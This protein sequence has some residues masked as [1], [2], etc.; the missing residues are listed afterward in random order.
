[1][2]HE[3]KITWRHD[4]PAVARGERRQRRND[5]ADSAQISTVRRSSW[6]ELLDDP[7]RTVLGDHV[8]RFGLAATN[9]ERRAGRERVGTRTKIQ[10][11]D[12]RGMAGLLPALHF[13]GSHRGDSSV[14]STRDGVGK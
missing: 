9:R 6:V 1:M 5:T 4:A 10:P 8:E 11:T 7:L 13:P 14:P 2:V 3:R 12:A